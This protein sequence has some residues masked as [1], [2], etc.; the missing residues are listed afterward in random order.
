MALATA[1]PAPETSDEQLLA[2]FSKGDRGALDELFR[3]Y[4]MTAYRVA[5]R[6]LGREADGWMPSGRF[7][8]SVDPSERLSGPLRSRPGC[9]VVSN[10]AWTSGVSVAVANMSA[11]VLEASRQDTGL[12]ARLEDRVA[13]LNGRTSAANSRQLCKNSGVAPANICSSRG[14]RIELPR[15]AEVLKFRSAPS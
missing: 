10:A 11:G 13:V 1:V 14:R 5:F 12:L 3:R 6:L 7:H 8:Q 9:C 4:R 2:R 15:V